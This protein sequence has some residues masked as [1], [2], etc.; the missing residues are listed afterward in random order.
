VFCLFFNDSEA[1]YLTTFLEKFR[2]F[3][4]KKK[5]KTNKK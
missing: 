3:V 4:L 5:R 2:T 1:G